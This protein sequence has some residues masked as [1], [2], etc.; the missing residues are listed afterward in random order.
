MAIK[1][2]KA[3]VVRLLL[4]DVRVDPG[5]QKM[6]QSD[7][8]ADAGTRRLCGCCFCTRV[9]IRRHLETRRCVL[10]RTTN[11]RGLSRCCYEIRE[12]IRKRND[13]KR[14][15]MLNAELAKCP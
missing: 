15:N 10:Q 13:A 1:G 2:K 11:M 12:L 7:A 5:L 3:E 6:R 14:L 4:G 8:P 9:L